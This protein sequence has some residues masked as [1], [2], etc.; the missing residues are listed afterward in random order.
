MGLGLGLSAQL[1]APFATIQPISPRL[2]KAGANRELAM[3]YQSSLG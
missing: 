1:A 3:K 2:Q